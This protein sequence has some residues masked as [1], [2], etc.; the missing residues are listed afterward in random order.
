MRTSIVALVS[1]LLVVGGLGP[2]G[3]AVA[4]EE[5]CDGEPITIISRGAPPWQ[6]LR[7]ALVPGTTD[8][9]VTDLRMDITSALGGHTLMAMGTDMSFE[10]EMTVVSVDAD[11]VARLDVLLRDVSLDVGTMTM[12]GE[13]IDEQQRAEVD[14]TMEA[15]SRSMVGLTGW[16]VVDARGNVLSHGFDLPESA[17]DTV[18]Q[19][20]DQSMTSTTCLPAGAV[21][22]GASWSSRAV[23]NNGV[24]DAGGT[25]VTTVEAIDGKTVTLAMA[26]DMD[27]GEAL[28]ASLA[29]ADGVEVTAIAS[30][31]TGEG[32]AVVDLGRVTTT[33]RMDLS[34][35]IDVAFEV[36]ETPMD[37]TMDFDIVV[38]SRP[39]G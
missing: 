30:S 19:Q 18:R 33:A 27:I 5:T 34:L 2:P 17:P 11:G 35:D 25:S 28:A 20:L 38:E 14:R 13:A 12:Q 15:L 3:V 32:H 6:E 23:S 39:P 26:I 24:I 4:Q 36:E 21:G 9:T 8:V 31:G 37:M 7:Y 29:Q 1:G 16:E 10:M 22:V